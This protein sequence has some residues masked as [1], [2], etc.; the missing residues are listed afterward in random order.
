MSCPNRYSYAN[1]IRAILGLFKNST[2][3]LSY[4]VHA[5]KKNIWVLEMHTD[6]QSQILKMFFSDSAT[7]KTYLNLEEEGKTFSRNADFFPVSTS[8]VP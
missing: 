1:L 6:R 8:A 3:I 7:L 4:E 5:L 2:L